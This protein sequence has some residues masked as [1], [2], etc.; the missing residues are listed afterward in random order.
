MSDPVDPERPRDNNAFDRP[1]GYSGQGYTADREAAEGD[2]AADPARPGE[3]GHPDLP[4]HNG[5][6]ASVDPATG[7]VG[8]A[9]M[10][11]GGGQAGEDLASE[12]AAGPGYPLTGGE[13]AAKAPGDLGPPQR[14]AT[15]YL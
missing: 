4:R 11:A 9:G 15:G 5:A 13:G 7:E 12:A 3:D 14:D 2:R 8:G 6:R 1:D 10:G